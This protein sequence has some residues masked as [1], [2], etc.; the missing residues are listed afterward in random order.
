MFIFSLQ[1]MV[2]TI[3]FEFNTF[4]FNHVLA[5]AGACDR[6]KISELQT[7]PTSLNS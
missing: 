2:F 4:K 1:K 3:L 5:E 6:Y 7:I